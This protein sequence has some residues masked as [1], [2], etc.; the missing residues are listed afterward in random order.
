MKNIDIESVKLL[1]GGTKGLLIKYIETDINQNRAFMEPTQKKKRA[2]I[3]KELEDCFSWLKDHLLDICGYTE[4]VDLQTIKTYT[5]VTGVAYG[6]K[7]FVITG[8][9]SVLDRTKSINLVTPL[10]TSEEEYKEF[11]AVC[12][13]MNGIYTETKA[14]MGGNKVMTDE[15]LILKFNKK[16]EEFDF[17]S[18]KHMSPSEKKAEATRILEEMGSIV[19]HNDEV[20]EDTSE[21]E[22]ENEVAQPL[23]TGKEIARPIAIPAVVS[24]MEIA[25][26]VD[27]ESLFDEV[28]LE[29]AEVHETDLSEL[30][31]LPEKVK[32]P[33]AKKEKVTIVEKDD[34]FSLAPLLSKG[35]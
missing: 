10:I 33:K 2:P 12:K 28:S 15:Q 1:E 27:E 34:D 25:E 11:S 24:K 3:H 29:A 30:A 9:L 32:A 14:Y 16:N 7:G 21:E 23:F 26:E 18:V 4:A 19:I 8:K 35:K 31:K 22:E 6:E 20:E 13:I 17:D 5:E